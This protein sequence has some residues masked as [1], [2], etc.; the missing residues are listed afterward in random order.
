MPLSNISPD[1]ALSQNLVDVWPAVGITPDR[2]AKF[3]FTK[4]WMKNPFSLVS[5]TK[6]STLK[7][8]GIQQGKIGHVGLPMASALAKQFL[9]GERL[10]RLKS[11]TE[12]LQAVCTGQ[13]DSGFLEVFNLDAMLLKRP[14]VCE[15]FQ[16]SVR[17]VNGA[18]SSV[19]I[20]SLKSVAYEADELRAGISE[21]AQEGALTEIMDQWAPNS[22]GIL[23]SFLSLQSAEKENR[24][25]LWGLI[26]AF[27]MSLV[28][29]TQ[30]LSA[31]RARAEAEKANA[32]KSEF[33]A[34]MSH[35][36]RTPMNGV[37]GMTELALDTE[38]TTEQR[39]YLNCAKV[40]AD[41]LLTVINDILDFSKIDAGKL[42]LD[43]IG[44][45]LRDCIEESMKL[46]ALKAHGKH[47]E[48][49]CDI[50]P[51]IPENVVGDPTRIR[52]IIINLLS[53]AIKF[54]DTGEVAVNVELLSTE[55]DQMLLH[56]LVRD[57]G[58]GI[59]LEKQHFIFEAFNQADCST[60]RQ[61]GGT[62]L[63][64]TISAQLVAIM[65]GEIWVN[66]VPG[67]GSCFHFTIGVGSLP[68]TEAEP[69]PLN[70]Q[71]VS[72]VGRKVLVVDDN[73]TN[74]RILSQT[75]QKWGIQPDMASS[76]GDALLLMSK[77]AEDGEPYQLMLTDGHMPLMDG[78]GLVGEIKKNPGLAPATI[79][80][81]TSGGQRGDGARC[82]ALGI[83][84]YL[85]KP[86]RAAELRDAMSLLFNSNS[87][88]NKAAIEIPTVT[89]HSLRQAR[90]LTRAANPMSILLA[91]DNPINQLLTLRIL[92]KKGHHVV[93]VSNGLKAVEAL[94]MKQ[95]DV[96]LMD[97]QMPEMSGLEATAVIRE[98]EK[99]TNTRVPIIAMT[100]HAGEAYKVSCLLAGMDAYISKPIRADELIQLVEN[101]FNLESTFGSI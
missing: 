58:V 76:A 24:L 21:L 3:H 48:L 88:N 9:P 43:P 54:T 12:V 14:A 61:F 56:F 93:V 37:L 50:A 51:A 53:N 90:S 59:P 60:T 96:V 10:E 29:F 87:E 89:N 71:N 23:R 73:S 13:I 63:G 27:A 30:I 55:K 40:S 78:F 70:I 5:L 74:L 64:L 85:T 17:L 46:M 98:N 18:N 15:G 77:A 39:D 82:R 97:V 66:S 86:V 8:S 52:Q 28:L 22:A 65:K 67:E 19:G 11:N 32:I 62:G 36:I 84:A 72:F 95:F 100:A 1:E 38:L 35:E 92:E 16:L 26:S 4:P 75:M 83:A 79:M 49:T 31:K 41:S 80:M 33:L 68:F 7:G 91:E 2:A 25:L 44:F 6:N 57:T 69:S 45:N 42:Q 99:G 34:N 47:L 101:C 94:T 81:L 20:A